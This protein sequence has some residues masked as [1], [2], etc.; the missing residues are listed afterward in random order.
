MMRDIFINQ[1]KIQIQAELTRYLLEE[2][3]CLYIAANDNVPGNLPCVTLDCIDDNPLDKYHLL[4]EIRVV[5]GILGKPWQCE[6][7]VQGLYQALQPHQVSLPELTVLLMSLHVETRQ[8]PRPD[9]LKQKTILRY[10]VEVM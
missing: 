4:S 6:A 2:D 7:L 5:L 10:V 8:W 9:Y 1:M 3:I